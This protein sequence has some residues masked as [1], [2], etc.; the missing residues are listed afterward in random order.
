[1]TQNSKVKLTKW[2]RSAECLW[3]FLDYDGT[4]E[5]FA[6]TPFDISPNPKIVHTLEKLTARTNTCVTVLSGPNLDHLRQLVPV[7]GVFLAGS[8]GIEILTPQH[9]TI[10]RLKFE[11]IRPLVERVKP[12]WAELIC[13]KRGFFLEDKG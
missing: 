13:G 8:Y 10:Y 9:E 5:E 4:L 2:A 6:P 7:R 1:M 3:L 12:Y 11:E